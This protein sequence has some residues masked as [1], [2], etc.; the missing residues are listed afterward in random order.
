[1]INPQEFPRLMVRVVLLAG[2]AGFSTGIVLSWRAGDAIGWALLRIAL[3]G[4]AFAWACRTVL[5]LC[6]K[7]WIQSRLDHLIA[8]HQARRK[9][10]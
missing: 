6:L 8:E 3:L 5:I 9:T 10:S 2:L 7:G 4:A 1:M